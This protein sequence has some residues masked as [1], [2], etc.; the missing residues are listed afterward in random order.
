MV[1]NSEYF[2][3]INVFIVV[4]YVIFALIGYK[5]G[6]VLQIIDFIYNILAILVAWFIS[7]IIAAHFPLVK[8]DEL[9]TAL[10]FDVLIDT[11]I[12]CVAIFLILKLIYMFIKPLF[13]GVSKLPLL[14]FIN[15]IGGFLLGVVNATII[16]LL[17]SLLL[18]TPLIENGKEIKE[19]TFLK[20][21]DNLSTKTMELTLKHINLEA[22]KDSIDNF[23]IDSSRD[24][25]EKWLIEQGILND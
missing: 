12:Y 23:D 3:Y 8:L 18:N 10:H 1:V 11:L 13:K 21:C 20:Y 17:L 5:N 7:P 22:I 2:I 14:G 16:V 15:K 6:L 25:F 19:N 9:Y 24:D 4:I